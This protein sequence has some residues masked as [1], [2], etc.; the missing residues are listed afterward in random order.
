MAHIDPFEKM[1][2]KQLKT[3][4]DVDQESRFPEKG[5]GNFLHLPLESYKAKTIENKPIDAKGKAANS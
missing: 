2:K 4:S 1:T 3:M 5:A